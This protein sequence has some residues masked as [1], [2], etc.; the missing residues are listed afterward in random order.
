MSPAQCPARRAFAVQ[1]LGSQ[2][3]LGHGFPEHV[4]STFPS[5][6][7]TALSLEAELSGSSRRRWGPCQGDAHVSQTDSGLGCVML[8]GGLLGGL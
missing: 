6:E 2:C 4:C 7:R 5:A 3:C 1:A 8:T